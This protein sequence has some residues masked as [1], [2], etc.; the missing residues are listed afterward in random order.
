M[1]AVFSEKEKKQAFATKRRMLIIWWALFALTVAAIAAMAVINSVMIYDS[2]DR[3]LKIPFMLA[4]MALAIAFGC[5]SVFFFGIK[6]RL[7]SRYCRMLTGMKRGIKDRSH[8]RFVA[9]DPKITE[10]DGVFFYGL[11][12]DCEPM[13]RGDVGERKVL[14]EKN[15]SLPKMDEG[16]EI[17]FITH[18]NILVAYEFD[19]DKVFEKLNDNKITQGEKL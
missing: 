11:I 5:G 18:A 4:S 12:L 6:Y 15:H 19:M 13:K 7:T 9:I 3:S 10:K 1:T 8:G 2:G 17:K 14:V 16:E